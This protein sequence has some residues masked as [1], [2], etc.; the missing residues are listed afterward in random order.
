MLIK[1]FKYRS[2]KDMLRLWMLKQNE[3]ELVITGQWGHYRENKS[4]S[5]TFLPDTGIHVAKSLNGNFMNSLYAILIGG[6]ANIGANFPSTY[7]GSNYFIR[8]TGGTLR[9]FGS[10]SNNCLNAAAGDSTV[11]MLYSTDT[12]APQ[13]ANYQI[14]SLIP[15]GTGAGQLTYNQGQCSQGP[16]ISGNTT[17]FVTYRMVTNNSGSSITVQKVYI[18]ID[19]GQLTLAFE[20]LNSNTLLNAQASGA[21]YTFA[22]TT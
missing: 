4:G 22:V 15:N 10:L 21:H 12:A 11:G 6:G 2:L 19:S 16:T 9:T 13:P 17:S 7:L 1:V 5:K 14:V 8:D 3:V 18:V 20:D